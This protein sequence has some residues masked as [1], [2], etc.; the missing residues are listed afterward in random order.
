M[1]GLQRINLFLRALMES[2]VVAGLGYYGYHLGSSLGIR[3][4]L[5]IVFPVVGFGF[6]GSVDF[7]QF[8][9]LSELLRLIQE[10]V[11]SGLAAVA[12]YLAGA[13]IIGWFLAILSVVHHILVYRLGDKLLK[14]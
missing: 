5:A 6:W 7:H 4:L 1:S 3:I 10:L 9:K 8:G 12:F 2:G 13:H 14:K 11:I